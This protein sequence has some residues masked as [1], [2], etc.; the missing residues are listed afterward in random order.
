MDWFLIYSIWL[1][2]ANV[3]IRR[4]R[5]QAVAKNKQACSW[6]VAYARYRYKEE[7]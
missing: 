5:A 1:G 7:T 6:L 4:K 2:M 3:D